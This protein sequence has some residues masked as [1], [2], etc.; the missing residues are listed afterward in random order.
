[1]ELIHCL[2]ADVPQTILADIVQII[3]QE[4]KNIDVVKNVPNI[5]D[6]PAIL[7]GQ[8]IDVLIIGM[9]SD[10]NS[11]VCRDLQLKC[12]DLLILGL[13]D[14]GRQAAIY[15]GD[16]GCN[17]LVQTINALGKCNNE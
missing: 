2:I 6:V 1:M 16:V 9:K 12:P 5:E 17:K 3:T 8:E 10:V 15:M 7:S 11:R 4:N 14:D 13:V